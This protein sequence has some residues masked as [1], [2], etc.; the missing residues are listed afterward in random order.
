MLPPNLLNSAKINADSVIFAY[1][2]IVSNRRR[3][4]QCCC[5]FSCSHAEFFAAF[6]VAA[7]LE[8]TCVE[9]WA[10]DGDNY[11]HK[12]GLY[13]RHAYDT[14]TYTA[15]VG[16]AFALCSPKRQSLLRNKI[17]VCK[18]RLNNVKC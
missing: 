11:E 9:I 8:D 5:V 2:G 10:V 4:K 6:Q 17:F 18:V 16:I 3:Y 12:V 1:C 15:D 7:P 14:F 13:M